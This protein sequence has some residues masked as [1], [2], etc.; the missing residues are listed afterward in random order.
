MQLIEVDGTNYSNISTGVGNEPVFILDNSAEG[1]S[2]T[3]A[4]WQYIVDRGHYV[5]DG[6]EEWGDLADVVYIRTPGTLGLCQVYLENV[7]I[8]GNLYTHA[9][10]A[11]TKK[12]LYTWQA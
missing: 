8:N 3:L 5:R 2:V 6:D 7:T 12:P 9:V 11:I 1:G 4:T 10:S